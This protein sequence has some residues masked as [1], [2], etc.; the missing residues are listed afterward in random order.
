M[1]LAGHFPRD[2]VVAIKTEEAEILASHVHEELVRIQNIL[3]KLEFITKDQET[4]FSNHLN[5]TIIDSAILL[6]C[7]NKRSFE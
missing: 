6:D 3:S 5:K 7:I 2:V 1:A 4:N